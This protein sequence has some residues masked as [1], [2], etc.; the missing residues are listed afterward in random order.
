MESEYET[1]TTIQNIMNDLLFTCLKIDE[2]QCLGNDTVLAVPQEQMLLRN[3]LR[4]YQNHEP[5]AEPRL[6]RGE[7]LANNEPLAEPRL[8]R[9][10]PLA[11]PRLNRGEPLAEPLANNEPLAKPRLTR[12]EP[13]EYQKTEN[14]KDFYYSCCPQKKQFR[15]REEENSYHDIPNREYYAENQLKELCWWSADEFKK[16]KKNAKM[17][18]FM[19]RC[20]YPE[21]PFEKYNKTLWFDYEE[22]QFS[23]FSIESPKSHIKEE[24]CYFNS[25]EPFSIESPKSHDILFKFTQKFK[26]I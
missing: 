9:G 3:E 22:K 21:I 14:V 5:L 25:I 23:P 4:L 10:E 1:K 8:N 15:I 16:I 13:V 12:G 2:T 18:L 20:R 11:E 24:N 19:F 17:E 6:N 26:L 7:P